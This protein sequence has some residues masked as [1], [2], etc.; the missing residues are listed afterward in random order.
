[1]FNVSFQIGFSGNT[2]IS[3]TT[4]TNAN[5]TNINSVSLGIGVWLLE[6][7][8][9][10]TFGSVSTTW[11]RVSISSTTAIDTT[12]CQDIGITTT[13]TFNNRVTTVCVNSAT[14]TWYLNTR[15]SPTADALNSSSGASY[16]RY[17]RL[18]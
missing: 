7:Y 13:G 18:A 2:S 15:I 5:P 12:R 6:G 4:P 9:T 3:T 10:I 14:T 16:I 1:M 17:T 11:F 8:F